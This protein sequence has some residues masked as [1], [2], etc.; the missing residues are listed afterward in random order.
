MSWYVTN[1]VRYVMFVLVERN[2]VNL[3]ERGR[4][5]M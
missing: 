1:L 3:H 5:A 2:A 4:E